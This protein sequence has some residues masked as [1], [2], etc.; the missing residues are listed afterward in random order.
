MCL[1]MYT[2]IICRF[3]TK[4]YTN[5]LIVFWFVLGCID[6]Q[7]FKWGLCTGIPYYFR[8]MYYLT[9]NFLWHLMGFVL[10]SLCQSL[11]VIV[12][13]IFSV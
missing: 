2:R 1:Y 12:N 8:S 6:L 3:V 13:S 11:A 10:Y 5:D 4:F 9:Y 7:T